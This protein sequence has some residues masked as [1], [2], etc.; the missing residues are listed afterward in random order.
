[1]GPL[2]AAPF[3]LIPIGYLFLSNHSHESGLNF[4]SKARQEASEISSTI[5]IHCMSF[6][7]LIVIIVLTVTGMAS[8]IAIVVWCVWCRRRRT[9]NKHGNKSKKKSHRK[10]SVKSSASF[11]SDPMSSAPGGS[12][13][14]SA[15]PYSSLGKPKRQ[16]TKPSQGI[17]LNCNN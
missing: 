16:I 7:T 13:N 4:K 9:P 6:P 15:Q 3:I 12:T 10:Q 11:Y 17:C 8:I 5:H 2:G 1:M 14:S